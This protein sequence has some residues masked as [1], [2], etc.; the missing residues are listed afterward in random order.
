MTSEELEAIEARL[1]MEVIHRLPTA[2]LY[3]EIHGLIAEVKRLTRERDALLKDMKNA[4]SHMVSAC[5][6][7]KFKETKESYDPCNACLANGYWQWRGVQEAD[8]A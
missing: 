3:N 4:V 6:L 8:N 7:C 1:T 2:V 5:Y